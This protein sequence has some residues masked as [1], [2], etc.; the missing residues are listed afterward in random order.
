VVV[1]DVRSFEDQ[2]HTAKRVH[3]SDTMLPSSP[4]FLLDALTDEAP[5]RGLSGKMRR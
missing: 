2:R 5:R 3:P 1:F 4:T